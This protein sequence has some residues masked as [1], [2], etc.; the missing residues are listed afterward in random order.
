MTN[1]IIAVYTKITEIKAAKAAYLKK[2]ANKRIENA[3]AEQAKA[4]K[5]VAKV[6]AKIEK[7]QAQI[8]DLKAE[9]N[10]ITY[11]SN[12]VV[13]QAQKAKQKALEATAKAEIS[14]SNLNEYKT[15]N[16]L[17]K[18][19]IIPILIYESITNANKEQV[20]KKVKEIEAKAKAKKPEQKPES[21]PEQKPEQK[22]VQ[23]AEQST[24]GK[25]EKATVNGRK[26]FYFTNKKGEKKFYEAQYSK[27]LGKYGSYIGSEFYEFVA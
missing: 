6:N 11:A 18:V 9:A 14:V 5:Q 27:K 20:E 25:P 17:E 23:K 13:A 26:G 24:E 2:V 16:T 12:Q 4:Q 19:L 8:N 1:I 3:K 22:P 10:A 7:L 15:L 21:K